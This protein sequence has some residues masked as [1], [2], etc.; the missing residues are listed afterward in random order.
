MTTAPAGETILFVE[1]D[2]PTRVLL[3]SGNADRKVAVRGGRKQA[4]HPFLITPFACD[5]L[6][7]TM[8]EQ[9]DASAQ[10]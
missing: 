3:L 4:R 2:P 8:R 5:Y 9:L 1:D 6:L 7:Q 10:P